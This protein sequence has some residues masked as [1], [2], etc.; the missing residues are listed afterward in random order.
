[1]TVFRYAKL[2]RDNIWSLEQELGHT[3]HGSR[4]HGLALKR[5]LVKKLVEEADEVPIE[6]G[7]MAAITEELADLQ[8]VLDDLTAECGVTEESVKL[9]QAAKFAK[10]GGF[11]GGVYIDTVDIPDE[12][13][14]FAIKFRQDPKKYPEVS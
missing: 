8:Q 1:M 10:K 3:P 9:V 14:P 13:D 2:V 4:L 12:N 11:R 7:D 5:A 6:S